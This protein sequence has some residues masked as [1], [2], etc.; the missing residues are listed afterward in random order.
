[1]FFQYFH[2]AIKPL[3]ESVIPSW[4]ILLVGDMRVNGK[5]ATMSIRISA[6]YGRSTSELAV[7]DTCPGLYTN[8]FHMQ[9][10]KGC[11]VLN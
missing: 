11:L 8:T 1:M 7:R 3:P 2:H 5:R 10:A 6:A 9:P 4:Q